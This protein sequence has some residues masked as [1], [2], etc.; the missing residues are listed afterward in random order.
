MFFCFCFVFL[1]RGNNLDF[2]ACFSFCPAKSGESNRL[3]FTHGMWAG[4]RIEFQPDDAC[5]HSCTSAAAC[6][7]GPFN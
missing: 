4:R 5:G 3:S 1:S 7:H 2:G 6:L